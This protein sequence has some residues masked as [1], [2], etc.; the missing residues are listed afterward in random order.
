MRERGVNKDQADL[1]VWLQCLRAPDRMQRLHAAN[2]LGVMGPLAQAAVPALIEALKDDDIHVR[3]TV[4][5]ALNE[6]GPAA[7]TSVPALAAS[8]RDRSAIVRR[9][10]A[11]ALGELGPAA[12]GALPGLTEALRDAALMVRRSAAFALGQ[13]EA[14]AVDAVPALVELLGEAETGTRMLASTVLVRIGPDATTALI[15]LLKHSNPLIRR[16]VVQVLGKINGDSEVIVPALREAALDGDGSVREAV[17]AALRVVQNRRETE[18]PK[19][20]SESTET[21][22]AMASEPMNSELQ[23]YAND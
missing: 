22:A 8:L 5:A 4:V 10:A 9:R 12:R 20:A 7:R 13:M 23:K 19:I 2:I 15:P 11:T 18:G 1:G 6:I 14:K 3:R 21:V 17:S 16:H